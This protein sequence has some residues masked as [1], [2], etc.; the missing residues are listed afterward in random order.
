M[1]FRDL[2]LTEGILRALH[3]KEYFDP[4]PIQKE[5]IPKILSNLDILGTAQTGTGKTAAYMLPIIQHFHANTSDKERDYF[6]KALVLCPTRELAIQIGENITQYAKYTNVKHVVIFGGVNQVKQVNQLK[7]KPEILIATPGRLL[8]LVGQNL[9]QLGEIQKF[10]LDEADRMLDMGFIHDIK[11]IDKLLPQIRQT[12]LFSATMPK[13]IRK[14]ASSLLRNHVEVSTS[15]PTNT[16]NLV[17]QFVFK[18]NRL[19]KKDLL[20]HVLEN[21]DYSQILL[22]TRTKRGADTIAKFLN[23]AGIKTAAIHG[24]KSQNARQHALEKFKSGE[25]PI[26]VATDIAARGID[27]DQLEVVINYELPNLPETYIHRVG[28]SGRNGYSGTAISLCEPEENIYLEAI[29]KLTVSKIFEITDHPFPQTDKPM[30]ASEKKEWNK[31]KQRRKEL[32]FASRKR[33]RQKRNA[34]SF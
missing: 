16:T 9:I 7:S 10:V 2:N 12:L 1:N 32:F 30:T 29:E 5:A 18:T 4:T 11:K 17:E 34:S 13:D 14:L 3:E 21:S 33:S 27:V 22:F 20:L 8:D 25:L 23:R 31:E 28:R 24:D 26:L 15:K 6:P 19:L